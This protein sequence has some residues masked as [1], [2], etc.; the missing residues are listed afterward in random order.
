MRPTQSFTSRGL[1]QGYSEQK[2][3]PL[4]FV[5][6]W[7]EG[8]V[9]S[10]P[11][12]LLIFFNLTKGLARKMELLSLWS[13]KEPRLMSAGKISD[14]IRYM[15]CED[16][17]GNGLVVSKKTPEIWSQNKT[18]HLLLPVFP[19]SFFF[20]FLIGWCDLQK[21]I[22]Q[23]IPMPAKGLDLL[24]PY[25]LGNAFSWNAELCSQQ[26]PSSMF[27]LCRLESYDS[28][29]YSWT[30]IC[31]QFLPQH[32]SEGGPVEGLFSTCVYHLPFQVNAVGLI[33]GTEQ[34]LI[35]SCRKSVTRGNPQSNPLPLPHSPDKHKARWPILISLLWLI[36]ACGSWPLPIKVSSNQLMVVLF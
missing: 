23:T 8:R 1:T 15:T 25:V 22:L 5:L 29:G 12:L 18:N 11:F 31:S 2:S 30:R 17:V 7:H 24:N 36:A 16:A 6:M 19:Y 21:N 10:L 14:V 28:W 33:N 34:R 13:F 32:G 9:P 4:D 27:L 20:F 3:G 26:K 35:V